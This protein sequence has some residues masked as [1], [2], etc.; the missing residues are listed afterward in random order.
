MAKSKFSKKQIAGTLL[1]SSTAIGATASGTASANPF[2][3]FLKN[4][5]GNLV[6]KAGTYAV[7]NIDK[8]GEILESGFNKIGDK[9]AGSKFSEYTGKIFGHTSSDKASAAYNELKGSTA[10]KW[11]KNSKVGKFIGNN[12]ST[13]YKH[14]WG[15]VAVGLLLV[16]GYGTYWAIKKVADYYNYRHYYAYENS[17]DRLLEKIKELTDILSP[18]K[19]KNENI[20]EAMNTAEKLSKS[21]NNLSISLKYDVFSDITIIQNSI[22]ESKILNEDIEA[23]LKEDIKTKSC[24]LFVSSQDFDKKRKNFSNQYIDKNNNLYIL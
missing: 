24:E 12:E 15:A 20:R 21:L 4:G 8:A 16:L 14:A 7:S 17:K 10:G 19:D 22:R 3:D 11:I 13:A 6:N 2:M 5:L 9:V 18:Y 23:K 1:L